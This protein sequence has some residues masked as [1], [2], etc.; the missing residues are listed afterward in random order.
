MKRYE[1]VCVHF[2]KG[3]ILSYV[4][5]VGNLGF[6]SAWKVQTLVSIIIPGAFTPCNNFSSFLG[7]EEKI[8]EF[9]ANEI[10]SP[11]SHVECCWLAAKV[12]HLQEV[13]PINIHANL[14]LDQ[15]R[16]DWNLRRRRRIHKVMTKAYRVS[17]T[18]RAENVILIY[19]HVHH[20]DQCHKRVQIW[21]HV[22]NVFW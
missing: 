19:R 14:Y 12:W 13:T 18:M 8:F 21:F 4:F 16:E 11:A 20:Q 22:L 9:L 1:A 7:F 6:W 15:R 10:I 17:R 2:P 3:P 5:S